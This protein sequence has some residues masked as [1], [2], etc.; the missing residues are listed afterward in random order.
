[1]MQLTQSQSRLAERVKENPDYMP[2]KASS[3]YKEDGFYPKGYTWRIFKAVFLAYPLIM[4]LS[5]LVFTIVGAV[6]GVLIIF[7]LGLGIFILNI[8]GAPLYPAYFTAKLVIARLVKNMKMRNLNRLTF[9]SLMSFVLVSIFWLGIPT[10]I[11]MLTTYNGMNLGQ[12]GYYSEIQSKVINLILIASAPIFSIIYSAM[13]L[14][15]FLPHA[16]DDQWYIAQ[17]D[18]YTSLIKSKKVAIG[19]YP[20]VLLSLL[21][22]NLPVF[23]E[24]LGTP[25]VEKDFVEVQLHSTTKMSAG[26]AVVNIMGRHKG[27]K[28]NVERALMLSLDAEQVKSILELLK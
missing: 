27:R 23:Q 14:A 12:S 7:V 25:A 9:A 20:V 2:G 1:M 16:I 18:D 11:Y 26:Y 21:N 24:V 6:S 5:G 15:I 4:L 3:T 8:I 17:D 28:V 19:G 10:G 22:W 13:G